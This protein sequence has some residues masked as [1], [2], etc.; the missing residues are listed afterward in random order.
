MT[1]LVLRYLLLVLQLAPTVIQ[2]VEKIAGEKD[3]ATKQ[4]L[5]HDSLV[6]ASGVAATV[7]PE[8]SQEIAA[9]SSATKSII[10]GTVAAYNAAGIFKKKSA[11]Q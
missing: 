4:Q 1:A 11:G 7:T 8:N 10:D 6:L 2:G 3:S 5:A 9:I